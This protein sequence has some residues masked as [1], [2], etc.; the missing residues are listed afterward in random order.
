MNIE[1]WYATGY[2]ASDWVA[3]YPAGVTPTSSNYSQATISNGRVGGYNSS[4]STTKPADDSSYHKTFTADGD[5][6]QFYFHSDY[7]SNYYGYYAIITGVE[8]K[9]TGDKEYKV[10]TKE[11]STLIGWNTKRDGTGKSYTS[12][13]EILNNIHNIGETLYA[14]WKEAYTITFEPNGGSIEENTRVVLKG[15]KLDEPTNHLDMPSKDGIL[16]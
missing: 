5:T 13:K 7:S 4:Y 16:I 12:E 10:P 11:G 15:D 2:Y 14:Q 8:K 6:A 3:I 1:I 9:Y